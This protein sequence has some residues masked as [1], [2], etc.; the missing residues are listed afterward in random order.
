MRSL[1]IWQPPR[2]R[3]QPLVY[4]PTLFAFSLGRHDKVS[5]L[6]R[7]RL[8]RQR[9]HL[10]HSDPVPIAASRRLA[11]PI[12]SDMRSAP[13]VATSARRETRCF[14]RSAMLFASRSL[15]PMTV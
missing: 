1:W 5:Y 13:T 10:V 12:F 7:R 8:T 6:D 4:C 3:V 2:N 9:K 15:M 11:L 14:F